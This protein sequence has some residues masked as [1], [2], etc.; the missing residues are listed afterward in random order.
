MSAAAV[1]L[2]LAPTPALLELQGLDRWCGWRWKVREGKRTKVPHIANRPSANAKSNNPSTWRSYAAFLAHAGDFDG[3]GFF[4]TDSDYCVL[5]MDRSADDLDPV[6]QELIEDFGSYVEVTPS[7]HLR[8]WIRGRKPESAGSKAKYKGREVEIYD[9]RQGGAR[10]LTVTGDLLGSIDTIEDGQDY[11]NRVCFEMWKPKDPPSPPSSSPAPPITTRSYTPSPAEVIQKI[12]SKPEMAALV[13]GDASGYPHADGTPHDNGADQALANSCAFYSDGDR[14][15]AERVF[16][17]TA[18]A[19]ARDKWFARRNYRDMT[20]DKAFKGK[21]YPDDFYDW[22][23]YSVKPK[24]TSS[25]TTNPK[26]PP[27]CGERVRNVDS[28]TL[29]AVELERVIWLRLGHIP[30][31]KITVK[32]GDPGLGKSVMTIDL[33]AR[34][35]TGREMPDGSPGGPAAD[36]MLMTS[37]DGEGDTVKPRAIAAGADLSRIHFIVLKEGDD[38]TLLPGIPTDIPAIET[39]ITRHGI[40]LLIIDPWSAF[41]D[42][43]VDSH[44]DAKVRRALAPLSK[45]AERT[46]CAVVLIR[47][48]VKDSDKKALYRGGGSIGII[49]AARAGFLV[50]EDN[51]GGDN[52]RV[53]APTKF[54]LGPR[55][56]ALKFSTVPRIIHSEGGDI[57]TVAIEW[58][59]RSLQTADSLLAGPPEPAKLQ[60]AV[61]FL[62]EQLSEKRVAATT[63]QGRARDQGITLA[64]LRRAYKKIGVESVKIGIVGGWTWQLPSSER[65]PVE[66]EPAPTDAEVDEFST[67][68]R[69]KSKAANNK[70][71]KLAREAARLPVR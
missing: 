66:Q 59:G 21:V 62:E 14:A 45:M 60:E 33:A 48:L 56:E 54:N 12:S 61:D 25:A 70:A 24:A 8:I 23:D 43:T 63:V 64:T 69:A 57:E 3:A 38:D 13:A 26:H 40:K 55:P 17:M 37:E 16:D 44:N 71:D 49:G 42:A 46:G 1:N 36:V 41:L 68:L 5:D 2:G 51:E 58:H 50:A 10:F 34:V 18:L 32:D 7:R 65:V 30:L 53:L 27:G 19:T 47:H 4:I 52:D 9:G 11:L 6:D 39:I 15:L 28:Y 29:A 31:G 67:Q 20:F 35:T 22:T